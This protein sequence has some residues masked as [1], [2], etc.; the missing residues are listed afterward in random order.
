[1]GKWLLELKNRFIFIYHK[2]NLNWETLLSEHLS[3]PRNGCDMRVQYRLKKQ[4]LHFLNHFVI[5]EQFW[6]D[7]KVFE[8][9]SSIYQSNVPVFQKNRY[10]SFD[11]FRYFFPKWFRF[12]KIGPFI[13]KPAH[14]PNVL[15]YF[16]SLR[17]SR[18]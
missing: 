4:I 5:S 14:I 8:Q 18:Y 15:L 9:R 10:F 1:M 2:Q 3:F 7:T 17:F 11:F 6:C 12:K 16:I 13:S